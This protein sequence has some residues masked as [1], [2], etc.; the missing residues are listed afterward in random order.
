MDLTPD[1]LRGIEF[2]RKGRGYDIDDVDAFRERVEVWVGEAQTRLRE[3]TTKLDEAEKRAREAEERSRTNVESDETIQRTLLLAQRTADSAVAEAEETAGRKVAEAEA[4]AER[5]TTEARTHRERAIADAEA[6]VR[7]AV[8]LKRAE[9]LDELTALERDRDALADDV[10]LLETHI[11]AQRG[12]VQEAR[13]VL[14]VLLDDPGSLALVAPPALSG[15]EV[16]V[17]AE[18]TDLAPATEPDDLE[19]DGS[20]PDL[21]EEQRRRSTPVGPTRGRRP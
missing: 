6:D 11:E 16:P 2:R 5:L 19:A 8:D 18:G 21:D 3:A 13:D 17:L 15:T 9:L 20:E 7:E 10:A 14:G 1:V 4:E 12:R